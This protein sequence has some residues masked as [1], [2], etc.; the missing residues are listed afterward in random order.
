ARRFLDLAGGARWTRPEWMRFHLACGG[1]LLW[2]GVRLWEAFGAASGVD[3]AGLA[4]LRESDPGGFA[5]RTRHAT[6]AVLLG[7][8]HLSETAAMI[9]TEHRAHPALPTGR[10]EPRA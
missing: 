3:W 2:Q 1:L 4:R 7:S 6:L 10:L 5:S 8:A 9:G